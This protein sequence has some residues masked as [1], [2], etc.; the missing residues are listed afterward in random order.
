MITKKQIIGIWIW[1]IGYTLL[2]L[3]LNAVYFHW[4]INTL[5]YWIYTLVYMTIHVIMIYQIHFWL[6]EKQNATGDTAL[7][8]RKPK[9][10][11][12]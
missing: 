2:L 6:S 11:N 10:Q 12:L 1:T 7:N 5:A 9:P 4:G 8:Y 3:Y